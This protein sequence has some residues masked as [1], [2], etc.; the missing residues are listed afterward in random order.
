MH[1]A[2][3]SRAAL[4]RRALACAGLIAL[5]AGL[6]MLGAAPRS[7]AATHA[8]TH[9]AHTTHCSSVTK[10][11]KQMYDP[12]TQGQFSKQGAV[13]VSQA[14]GLVNQLVDVSWKNFTPSS[15]NDSPG[16]YYTN[17]LTF[18]GVMVTECRGTAPTSMDSCY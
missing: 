16:P 3:L 9:A 15:P 18:Y 12:T 4:A 6:L 11:G 2:S 10:H 8:P 7:A 14:C 13:T 5:G 1:D 17:T